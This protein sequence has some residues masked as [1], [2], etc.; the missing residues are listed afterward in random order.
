[1]AIVP[2]NPSQIRESAIHKIASVDLACKKV[3][4][5]SNRPRMETAFA[6]NPILIRGLTKKKESFSHIRT[7]S[8]NFAPP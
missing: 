4:T 7:T 8:D 3:A 1:M 5:P 6:D 2:S